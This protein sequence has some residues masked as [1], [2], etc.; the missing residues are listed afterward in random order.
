ITLSLPDGLHVNS[1][2]PLSEYSIP[3]TVRLSATKGVKV[4]GPTYPRGKTKTFQF[5]KNPINVYEGVVNFPFTFIVPTNYTGKTVTVRAV[6]RYQ[7]CTDSICYPPKTQT[8][9]ITARVK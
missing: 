9:L 6:V 5:S 4:Y 3:T 8:V 1:F 7:A 2:R